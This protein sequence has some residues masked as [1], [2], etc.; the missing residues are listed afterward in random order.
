MPI[1][2]GNIKTFKTANGLGGAITANESVS[3]DPNNVFDTFSGAETAAGGTFYHCLY[4]KNEHASLTAQNVELYID[5]ETAHAGVNVEIGLGSSAV[6]AQEQ[7][8]QD[9]ET[10][11]SGVS[12]S[13]A[14]GEEN[15]LVIGDIPAG[16]HKAFWV[17]VTIAPGTTAKTG[18]AVNT[19]YVFDTAE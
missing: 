2:S 6:N 12:F 17:K 1:V 11:P 14:D 19:K 8:I 3:G 4:V 9:E 13:E 5:S 18:Y 10:A 7:T 16:Q 15:A